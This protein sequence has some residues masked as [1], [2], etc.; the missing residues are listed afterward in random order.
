MEHTPTAEMLADFF[1][2]PLQGKLLTKFRKEIPNLNLPLDKQSDDLGSVLENE[3]EPT[4][5]GADKGQTVK[6]RIPNNKQ[7]DVPGGHSSA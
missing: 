7:K 4:F 6:D 3:D 5:N 2:K 1:T